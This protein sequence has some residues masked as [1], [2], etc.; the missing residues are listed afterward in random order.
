MY[1]NTSAAEKKRLYKGAKLHLAKS[2]TERRK[3]L[4]LSQE[5]LGFRIGADQAYISRVES[6]K[7]NPTLETIAELA[8]A[9]EM[10][11]E[12]FL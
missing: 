6:G 9:L 10:K 1:K 12:T 11:F 3:A 5:D 8:E 2:V 7:L 4:K